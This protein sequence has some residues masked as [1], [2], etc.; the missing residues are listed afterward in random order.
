MKRYLTILFLI[1]NNIKIK[2]A[3][4][5]CLISVLLLDSNALPQ[6]IGF[7]SRPAGYL[8]GGQLAFDI[9]KPYGSVY[10][11][12][13]RHERPTVIQSGGE[14]DI[15]SKLGKQLYLPKFILFQ[16]TLYQL[17]ALS[18]YLETDRSDNPPLLVYHCFSYGKKIPV[19]LFNKKI[20][21]ILAG[22]IR[23][24]WI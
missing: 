18:T 13:K 16:A 6:S 24:E 8:F 23:W 4:F 10:M 15:Y 11:N 19:K 12:L 17:S 14:V 22:G 5:A 2:V 20:F 21:L 1:M 3:I 9:Y 7:Q